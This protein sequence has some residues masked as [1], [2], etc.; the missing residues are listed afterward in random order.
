MSIIP[1]IAC[2]VS[3]TLFG[4]VGIKLLTSKDAKKA[5]VHVTAAGLRAKDCVMTTV[6]TVQ[7]NAN[8]ILASAQDLNE[9]R[10]A[11]EEAEREAAEIADT[12]ASE[13][14]DGEEV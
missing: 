6:D 13:E 3:G 9:E 5:Y 8:D 14:A 2:F 12:E 7:E 1:K 4:S 11:R 10:A